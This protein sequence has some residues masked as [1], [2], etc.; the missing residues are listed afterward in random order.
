M[1][2][3]LTDS[4]EIEMSHRFDGIQI[5]FSE[6]PAPGGEVHLD[7][8]REWLQDCNSNHINPTCR[9]SSP[10][11]KTDPVLK[12]NRLIDLADSGDGMVRLSLTD[13]SIAVGDWTVLD[14]AW[15]A[16]QF[17]TTKLSNLSQHIEGIDPSQ[18]P[19]TFQDAI[20]VTRALGIRYLWI[21][22][23]CVVQDDHVEREREIRIM[24]DIIHGAT[25]VLAASSR[26][27]TDDG[28]LRPRIERNYVVL[29]P[30]SEG[31]GTITVCDVIDDFQKHVLEGL[32]SSRGWGLESHALARRTIF[33]TDHQMYWECGHGV[34][35]ETMTKLKQY[36]PI[37]SITF[38]LLMHQIVT[39]PPCWVIQIFLARSL[40]LVPRSRSCACKPSTAS[41]RDE[42]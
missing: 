17:Y 12:P 32:L 4:L 21:D 35:C 9:H 41:I 6:L 18:L 29:H 26:F 14:Y 16:G 10:F 42:N 8:L 39:R 7:I 34:R 11:L 37:C 5:G 33:F 36:V 23:I 22:A 19:A 30:N 1:S 27:G 28:L 2:S 31:N 25:C 13:S 24:G 3:Q 20:Q 40:I 38:C 15:G